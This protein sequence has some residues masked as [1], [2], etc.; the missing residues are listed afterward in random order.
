MII[1]FWLCGMAGHHC[2]WLLDLE[3]F[4]GVSADFLDFSVDANTL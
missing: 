1:Q 3:S 2:E 4:L